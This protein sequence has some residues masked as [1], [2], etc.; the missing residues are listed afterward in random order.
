[1]GLTSVKNGVS[2]MNTA[3]QQ[4]GDNAEF[5]IDGTVYT[6]SSNT[7]NSDISRIEGVTLNLKSLSVS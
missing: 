7:I 1:M 4:V 6:S 2:R 5:T 3:A